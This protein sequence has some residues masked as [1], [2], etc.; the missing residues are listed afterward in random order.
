[1]NRYLACLSLKD[2][3]LDAHNVTHVIFLE[4]GVRLLAHTVSRHIDLNIPLQILHIAEGSLAH[5][6]LAHNTSRNGNAFSFQRVKVVM[7][8]LTV[9]GYVI[10]RDLKGISA[11]LLQCRKL[12]PSHLQKLVDILFLLFILCICHTAALS[13]NRS[14]KTAINALQCIQIVRSGLRI[15]CAVRTRAIQL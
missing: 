8:F 13:L 6:A 2:L 5:N 3:A 1:M 11:R 12:L 10:F 15:Y 14:V 7:N 9:T 4:I